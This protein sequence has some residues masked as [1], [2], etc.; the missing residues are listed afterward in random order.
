M[1]GGQQRGGIGVPLRRREDRRLLTGAGCYSDDFR[2]P[3]Q[4]YMA[5]LRSPHAHAGIGAIDTAAA[6]AMSGVLAVLTGADYIDDG[7]APLT[8]AP[9]AQSPPDIRL[10]NTD[11]TPIEAPHQY[12]LAIDRARFVGEA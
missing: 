2:V 7:F 8:H 4:A 11:G 3:D 5:V 10:E 12:P 9:A 6:R 1:D